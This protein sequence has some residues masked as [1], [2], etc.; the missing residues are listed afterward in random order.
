MLLLLLVRVVGIVDDVLFL[1][2][3]VLLLSYMMLL[4]LYCA[5]I[6]VGD[7]VTIR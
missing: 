7:S 2:L 3:V 6:G 5:V 1:S 4:L